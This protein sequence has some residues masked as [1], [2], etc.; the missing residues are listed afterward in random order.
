MY[1]INGKKKI[2]F[3]LSGILVLVSIVSLT[4]WGLR[5]GIDFTGGSLLE[6]SYSNSRPE[7]Y[8]I[9]E[10]MQEFNLQSLRIQPTD[11]KEYLLRFDN[12]EETTHQLIL[13]KLQNISIEGVEEN[14]VTENRFESIGPTIGNELKTKAIESI[15]IVLAFI[16]FYIAYAFR[17]VS[18]PV[19]SW[20]YGVAAI[21]ALFHDILIITGIF[22]LMGYFFKTEIDT[23]FVTAL[24]T[25]LGFSVHDTIVTF[26]RIR[27]N[28][29][30][31]QDKSFAEIVNIS[32]NQTF[33][34]S[35]N[36]SF[37]TLLVLLAIYFF[38]GES[39]KNFTLALILGVIIGTYSSIF[40]ASPL[41]VVW[42]KGK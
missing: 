7:I 31:N 4:I 39:I 28:L 27:E 18:K 42:R 22:S 8:Q 6:I 5:L 15:F 34:R 10:A 37:T 25:I 41:L 20:K 29:F 9:E 23:L 19:P 24:L 17:K 38:G 32:I 33:L 11:Q 35:I 13:E 1:D 3:G 26:D 12:V 16:V 30:K 40:I 14:I 36:T 2:W 21:I